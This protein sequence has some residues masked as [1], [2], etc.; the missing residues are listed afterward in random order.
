MSMFID[1]AFYIIFC[2]VVIFSLFFDSHTTVLS[3]RNFF[4]TNESA[5]SINVYDRNKLLSRASQSAFLPVL[6]FYLIYKD[7][8]FNDIFQLTLFSFFLGHL[9]CFLIEFHRVNN[10]FQKNR[11]YLF[12]Q[13]KINIFVSLSHAVFDFIILLVPISLNLIAFYGFK[14][15]AQFIVQLIVFLNGI[16]I[17]YQAYVFKYV[18]SKMYDQN[19]FTE[20]D[21]SKLLISKM[22]LRLILIIAF[23]LIWI[24]K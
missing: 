5:I 23:V 14:E 24:L 2:G 22:L 8:S 19:I 1:L 3:A 12:N 18:L 4:K 21:V 15:Y 7:P 20:S 10:E 17:F 9:L 6:S 16:Y 11:P 13:G